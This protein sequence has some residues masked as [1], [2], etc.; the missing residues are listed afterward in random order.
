MSEE[1]WAA[2]LARPYGEAPDSILILW[3]SALSWYL[4]PCASD[5]L[6]YDVYRETVA[7]DYG[8][9][10]RIVSR[11]LLSMLLQDAGSAAFQR[12]YLD[13]A[14]DIT[15]EEPGTLGFYRAHS[16]AYNGQRVWKPGLELF[17]ALFYPL[18]LLKWLSPLAVLAAFWKRG[19]LLMTAAGI[20][21]A[22]LLLIASFASIEPRHYVMPAQLYSLL[23]GWLLGECARLAD[24]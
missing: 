2:F 22:S 16:S 24:L 11:W 21:L 8:R 13:R 7:S 14:E 17:S 3:H 15:W 9:I 18:N 19:W 5:A 1:E 12:Q 23:I 6:L 10:L 4:G 20:L